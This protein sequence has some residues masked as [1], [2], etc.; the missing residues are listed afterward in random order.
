MSEADL[1][2]AIVAEAI[3][4]ERTPYHGHGR[5]KG[6]GVDCAMYPALVFEACG[7]CPEVNPEYS[8]QWM[9]HRDEEIYLAEIRRWA[10]DI[11]ME[12]VK[13]GDLIVWKWGRTYSHSAIVIEP[14]VVIHAVIDG[15][16]VIRADYSAEE[17]LKKRPKMAFSVFA[18]DGSP[19]RGRQS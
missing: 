4:W 10:R 1:R 12:E 7:H 5:L 14:P 13:P 15:G 9:K 3:T 11:A 17:E 8:E 16:A 18:A 6:V 2:A 19:Y